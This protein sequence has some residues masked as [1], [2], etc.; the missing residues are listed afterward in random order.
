[1][2]EGRPD[3]T[4]AEGMVFEDGIHKGGEREKNWDSMRFILTLEAIIRCAAVLLY[5]GGQVWIESCSHGVLRIAPKSSK[6]ETLSMPLARES[7]LPF[8]IVAL[9]WTREHADLESNNRSKAA[10]CMFLFEREFWVGLSTPDN[11]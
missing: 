4:R 7:S 2:V 11:R 5:A 9:S 10:L 3:F 1:M 6:S 8:Q